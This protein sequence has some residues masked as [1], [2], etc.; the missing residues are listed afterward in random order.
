MKSGRRSFLK[1]ATAALG[2]LVFVAPKVGA[3][4]KSQQWVLTRAGGKRKIKLC[5]DRKVT[6]ILDIPN[7]EVRIKGVALDRGELYA[8]ES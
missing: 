6:F 4:P 5:A 1:T 3:S 8:A 7:G 2:S